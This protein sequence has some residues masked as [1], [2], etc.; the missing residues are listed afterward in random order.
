MTM[1]TVEQ[2]Y[3][4]FIRPMPTPEKLRLVALI[5][6]QLATDLSLVEAV[7][8]IQL[9]ESDMEALSDTDAYNYI[10]TLPEKYRSSPKAVLQL[11]DTLDPEEAD[12]ILQAA[13]TSRRIDPECWN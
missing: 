4:K 5:T 11:V 8:D 12:A 7:E 6:G 9:P 10:R 3:E 2:F 1:I 13:Q